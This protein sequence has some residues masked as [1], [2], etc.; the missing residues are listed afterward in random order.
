MMCKEDTSLFVPLSLKR[1]IPFSLPLDEF[2]SLCESSCHY[3]G[4][5]PDRLILSDKH[6]KGWKHGGLDRI[7]PAMGYEPSNVVPCCEICNTMKASLSGND[8]LA[9][10]DKVVSHLGL[11]NH[12]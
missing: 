2:V 5:P 7:D 1:G 9:H 6:G 10:V 3:C 4:A 12:A 11:N 8:F